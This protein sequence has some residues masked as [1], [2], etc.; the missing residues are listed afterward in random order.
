MRD[1]YLTIAR[2][3]ERIQLSSSKLSTCVRL[4]C[5]RLLLLTLSS[6]TDF[7]TKAPRF[8]SFDHQNTL[9]LSLT[10]SSCFHWHIL[11]NLRPVAI[12]ITRT[13]KVDAFGRCLKK[14]D[15]A[16]AAFMKRKMI[17]SDN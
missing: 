3:V 6:S 17:S 4:C 2:H 10:S 16:A 13:G 1:L 7:A 14:A 11:L 15:D 5:P 12:R 9:S 8:T